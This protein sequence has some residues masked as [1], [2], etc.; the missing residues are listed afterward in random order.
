PNTGEFISTG[1][2]IRSVMRL[3]D[4]PEQFKLG[5]TSRCLGPSVDE[6]SAGD[7]ALAALMY[8]PKPAEIAADAPPS[9]M[10]IRFEGILASEHFGYVLNALYDRGRIAIKKHVAVTEETIKEVIAAERLSPR[11]V[12]PDSLD[13]FL[14]R[15]NPHIC[16]SRN[17]KTIWTN[18]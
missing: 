4:R 9:Q 11:G 15:I 8:P 2:D 1:I 5:A 17:G 16:N 6:L 7:R 12:T 14:C 13:Q 18:V 10:T 3:F